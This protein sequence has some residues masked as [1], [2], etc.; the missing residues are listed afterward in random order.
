LSHEA[1]DEWQPVEPKLVAE[2]QFVTSPADGFVMAQQNS[3]GGG[4]KKTLS[5]AL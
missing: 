4:P 5:N 1:F 3:C 2:V